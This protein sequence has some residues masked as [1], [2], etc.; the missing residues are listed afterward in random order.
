[1]S[2]QLVSCL[3]ETLGNPRDRVIEILSF[4]FSS[5]LPFLRA[6]HPMVLGVSFYL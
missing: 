6:D 3:H 5:S 4:V 1:M 2:F